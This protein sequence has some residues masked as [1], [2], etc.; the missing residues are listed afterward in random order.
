ME[1][2]KKKKKKKL[3]N[4]DVALFATSEIFDVSSLERQKFLTWQTVPRQNC[5]IFFFFFFF[6]FQHF[7]VW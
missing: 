7:L 3:D 6:K 2:K 1:K 5:P 4:S